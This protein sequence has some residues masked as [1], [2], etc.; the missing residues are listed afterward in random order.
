MF[1]HTTNLS[2][3][4]EADPQRRVKIPPGFVPPPTTDKDKKVPP[5]KKDKKGKKDKRPPT[6]PPPSQPVSVR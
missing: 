3:K 5:S 1:Y 2:L 4:P 6:E